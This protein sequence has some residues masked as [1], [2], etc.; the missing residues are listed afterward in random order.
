[1]GAVAGSSP[2]ARGLRQTGDVSIVNAGIIPARAGFTPV[3]CIPVWTCMDHPRSRGVYPPVDSALIAPHGSS[4]LARGL[5]GWTHIMVI[6]RGIIPARA[7]FTPPHRPA[8]R[9][10]R[11]HP[12]SRGVYHASVKHDSDNFGS[13]P[14]ARGLRVDISM[15]RILIRIIPARAGFT[16]LQHGGRRA[17]RDHPRSRGVYPLR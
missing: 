16:G 15:A 7:G 12:R 6:N 14:L 4:P 11:D 10:R 8:G 9:P 17:R 2:L 5:R 1:M 13:S 3:F